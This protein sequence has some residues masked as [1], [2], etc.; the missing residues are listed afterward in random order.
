MR[1]TSKPNLY[2]GDPILV[3][4]LVKTGIPKTIASEVLNYCIKNGHL[5][6]DKE[7]LKKLIIPNGALSKSES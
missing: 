1:N 5:A 7:N 2:L 3:D 4:E 6:Y